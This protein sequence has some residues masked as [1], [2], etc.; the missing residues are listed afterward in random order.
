MGEAME[1][2]GGRVAVRKTGRGRL[3]VEGTP[4]ETYFV[5]RK[6]VYALHAQAG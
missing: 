5:V 4:G 6:A 2:S 3:V 1:A